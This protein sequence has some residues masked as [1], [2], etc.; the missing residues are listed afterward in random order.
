MRYFLLLCVFL[1]G[2]SS[3]VMLK[4]LLLRSIK[5]S[6]SEDTQFPIFKEKGSEYKSKVVDYNFE[7]KKGLIKGVFTKE[8]EGFLHGNQVKKIDDKTMFISGG[9]FT[10][11]DLEHPHFAI[12]FS[13]AKVVAQD[14]IVT[15]PAWFSIMDI[16]L[17][18]AIPFGYFLSPDKEKSGFLMPTYG[19]AGKQRV[20]SKKY[21]LVFCS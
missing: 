9:K 3:N 17:P 20:L 2:L 12:N 1:V 14:K 18:L 10:T 13:K 7:T 15:G 8:G 19:Y 11:C 21:R 4:I 16:P 5:D 6:A